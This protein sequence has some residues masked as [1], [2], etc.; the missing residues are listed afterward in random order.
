VVVA[1]DQL[2]L[3]I[4]KRGQNVRLAARLTGWDIDILTPAEYNKGL[5]DMMKT[6]KQIEG[7]QDVFLDQLLAMGIIS[8]M[9]VK[10]VGPE[11]LI[12]ELGQTAELAERIVKAAAEACER[13][14]AEGEA[15]KVAEARLAAE[16][17]LAGVTE[18]GEVGSGETSGMAEVAGGDESTMASVSE[19]EP[20]AAPSEFA[21]TGDVDAPE[22][23]VPEPEEG[24]SNAGEVATQA[25]AVVGVDPREDETRE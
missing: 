13:I 21:Q 16:R 14:A 1:E 19:G 10:E 18:P 11:P 20:A 9:D 25:S 17:A 3:A 7:V 15:R 24:G 12:N 5:D 8:P 22:E 23:S 2:S 4:G 6:L